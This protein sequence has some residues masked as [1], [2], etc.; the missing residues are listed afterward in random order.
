MSQAFGKRLKKQLPLHIFVWMGLLFLLLFSIIPMLGVVIGFKDYNIKTGFW[1]MFTAPWVGLKHFV[2]FVND[3]KFTE[4]MRNTVGLAALKLVFSFPLPILFAVMITEMRGNAYKRL[5]QTA[6][7]LPHFI[8]WTIVAGILHA[9][10]STSTGMVNDVLV[11]LGVIKEPLP[12]LISADYYY[13]LAVV[14]E[15]WKGL[16]W[17]AIIYLAAMAG[18]DPGLY[19]S[20]QIDGAGRLRRIWHV[21]LPCIKGTIAVLLILAMGGLFSGN[22]EQAMLL[23]NTLNISRSQVIE[24]FVYRAGLTQ[25]RYD[26]AAAAGLFQSV[27]SL[28]L[29]IGTNA[30]SRKLTGASLF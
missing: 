8:S 30:A 28:T 21:T 11:K 18:I 7:Y 9:F 27:L 15:I 14:S 1:G 24:V 10:F 6:S 13:G 23:G 19:E 26:Y 20:A 2:A 22:F 12:I 5:V 29:V 17:N 16:G 25:E 4:L 3:R